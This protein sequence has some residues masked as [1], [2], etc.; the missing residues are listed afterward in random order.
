ML[1]DVIAVDVADEV[2]GFFREAVELERGHRY[3]V[4]ECGIR[5]TNGLNIAAAGSSWSL[6]GL[7]AGS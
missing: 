4:V 3:A 7:V 6:I 2:V 1:V 5:C